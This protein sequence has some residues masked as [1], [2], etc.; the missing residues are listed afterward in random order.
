MA[1][2]AGELVGCSWQGGGHR[3]G[4]PRTPIRDAVVAVDRLL[5]LDALFG[6]LG[7]MPAFAS[8]VQRHAAILWHQD[9]HT[10]AAAH[11]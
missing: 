5:G 9:V 8:D 2:S 11:R 4:S 7:R 1:G 10:A 3:F 6:Q